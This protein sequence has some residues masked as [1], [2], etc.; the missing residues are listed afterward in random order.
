MSRTVSAGDPQKKFR[1]I[2]W[3]DDAVSFAATFGL[4]PEDCEKIL[5][6]R[7]SPQMDPRSAEVGHL[8]VRYRAGDVIVV[9]GHRDPE[10]PVIMSVMVDTGYE[11]NSGSKKATGLSGSTLP[12]SMKQL[13]KRILNDGFNVVHGGSHMRVEDTE[14]ELIATLPRTPSDHRSIPNSWKAYQ[15]AKIRYQAERLNQ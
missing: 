2:S 3:H 13:T 4:E 9:V 6:N 7:S 11:G 5:I 8:I 15:R 1:T 14:G 12:T 10:H